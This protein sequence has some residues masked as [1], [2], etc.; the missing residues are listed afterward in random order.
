MPSIKTIRIHFISWLIFIL[1]ELLVSYSFG[2]SLPSFYDTAGH[3]ILNIS[4]FYIHFEILEKC[5][6]NNKRSF[7]LSVFLVL[8]E[9]AVY[10]GLK[11]LLYVILIKFNIFKS[12]ELADLG[13]LV[14]HGLW[15]AVY[16]IGLST[17]FWFA[18]TRSRAEKIIVE[19]E[20]FGLR[21]I[22]EKESL[23][24]KLLISENSYLKA[25]INPHFLFNVLGFIHNNISGISETAGE[26]IIILSDM[27]RYALNKQQDDNLVNLSSEIEYIENY[28]RINQ[29]R[30]NHHLNLNFS[31]SGNITEVRVPALLFMTI[32]ENVFKYADLSDLHFPAYIGFVIKEEQLM[33]EIRNK[34]SK[35]KTLLGHGIGMANVVSRLNLEYGNK[36]ELTVDNRDFEYYLNLL[37]PLKND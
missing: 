25:Q 28:I 23:E 19:L 3:Y 30:F 22:L 9:L 7:K 31:Y 17:G 20:N 36:Y 6:S 8:L 13:K 29:L 1:Y 27:M 14:V 5:F 34:K 24:K 11:Y 18:V 4:V 16:F 26:M 35:S 12:N 33:F 32:V 2:G 37:I 21:S 10:L 15:R